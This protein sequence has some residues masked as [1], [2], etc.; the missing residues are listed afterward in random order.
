MIVVIGSKK[1][2]KNNPIKL[3][4]G[5]TKAGLDVKVLYWEDMIFSIKSK[6]VS[7]ACDDYDF[8]HNPPERVIALGWY[9]SVYRDI[10]FSLALYLQSKGIP[11]WN[12][13]MLEQ[14][15]T[16][17][18]STMVQ[19][20]LAG[21]AVPKTIFC[22][23]PRRRLIETLKFPVVVK[24]I[25]VSRGEN[26][27]LIRNSEQLDDS[28]INFKD[29]YVIQ[30]YLPNDHDLRVIC[31]G[32][33]P[34]MILRRSAQED[35]HLNNTSQGGSAHWV[36]ISGV[37]QEILTECKNICKIMKREMAGIDLIPDKSSPTGYSCLEVNAIPQLTS[38]KD[39]DRKLANLALFLKND[40]KRGMA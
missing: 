4:H 9:K 16:T 20:A 14:R 36:N 38:G 10:A 23:T 11:F 35:T 30:E 5:L 8:A 28:K 24:A 37:K 27:F 25:A 7:V 18:L 13:E 19:L 33:I 3:S 29:G 12:S 22:L 26:N 32:G 31:Y 1:T 34:S 39:V 17:K 15:S 2:K 40:E 21:I 6:S